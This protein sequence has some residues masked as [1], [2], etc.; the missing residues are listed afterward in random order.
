MPP[1][2][3]FYIYRYGIGLAWLTG[4]LRLFQALGVNR[5]PEYPGVSGK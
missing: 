5:V 1:P 2:I 3:F 4:V